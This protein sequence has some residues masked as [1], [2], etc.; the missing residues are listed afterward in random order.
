MA[1]VI[2]AGQHD[3]DMFPTI[4][5]SPLDY[6]IGETSWQWPE[7]SPIK[8]KLI[9]LQQFDPDFNLFR[10]GAH[11][12]LMIYVGSPRNTRRTRDALARREKRAENRGWGWEAR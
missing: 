11:M 10:R 2:E 8:Q 1:E 9:L 3:R 4:K 5:G 7:M 12:P 6:T